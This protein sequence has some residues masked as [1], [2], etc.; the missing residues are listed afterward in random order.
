MANTI[1]FTLIINLFY[2]LIYSATGNPRADFLYKKCGEERAQ[3]LTKY[4]ENYSRLL[5]A[6]QEEMEKIGFAMGEEGDEPNRIYAL[7]QCMNDLSADECRICFSKI[8]TLLPG[9]FPSSGGRVFLDGCFMRIENYNFFQ[10]FMSSE[11]VERCSDEENESKRYWKIATKLID[12]LIEKA[13][14]NNGYADGRHSF[15]GLSVYGM[16]NCWKSFDTASCGLCLSNARHFVL[17]CLPSVEA[18]ALTAGCYL[19]YSDYDFAEKYAT[20]SL[21]VAAITN[22]TV[23][24]IS[25]VLGAIAVCFLA[26]VVGYLVGQAIVRRRLKQQNEQKAEYKGLEIDSFQFKYTTLEKAT[27]NFDATNKIGQGGFGEVFKGTLGDGREIAIKRLY[28]SGK[29]RFSEIQNEVD[30]IGEAQHKNL[31]RYL[32][33]C[34][35][36]ED[37]LLVYE[38]VPNRSLDLILFG[39]PRKEGRV[40]VEEKA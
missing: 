38:F 15:L 10:E 4:N 16:A 6:M 24:Y 33:C 8:H 32:G 20:S 23:L 31:A 37:S 5:K 11:D 39:R 12:E 21:S 36:N 35:T 14:H 28:I 1:H 3:N 13:P 18:R 34:F 22:D 9:C 29:L 25:C 30:I 17:N 2:F 26:I 19:R 7:G 27:Q 40:R